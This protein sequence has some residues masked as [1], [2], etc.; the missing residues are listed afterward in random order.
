MDE[1][2][3]GREVGWEARPGE[4]GEWRPAPDGH[5]VGLSAPWAGSV[6]RSSDDTF[7]PAWLLE[8]AGGIDDRAWLASQLHAHL[9]LLG[10]YE[11]VMDLALGAGLRRVDRE[12]G[13]ESLGCSS[14]RDLAPALYGFS[15]SHAKELM[16]LHEKLAPLPR[17]RAAFVSNALSRSKVRE[18]ARVAKPDDEAGWLQVGKQSSVRDLKSAI[19]DWKAGLR[20]VHAPTASQEAEDD[21]APDTH[22]RVRW[23]SSEVDAAIFSGWGR[24]MLCTV[25]GKDAPDWQLAEVLAAETLADLGP[26]SDDDEPRP[27]CAGAR[28][29][30]QPGN[31]P[32]GR[33]ATVADETGA[34]PAGGFL[35]G[36]GAGFKPALPHGAPHVRAGAREKRRKLRARELQ[37]LARKG[38]RPVVVHAAPQLPDPM[39]AR[40]ATEVHA[41]LFE[42]VALRNAVEW[43]RGQLLD[44]MH[45]RSLYRELGVRTF[46]KYLLRALGLSAREGFGAVKL[47]RSLDTLPHVER[48]LREARL[49]PRT[50]A[51]LVHD[52]VDREDEGRGAQ[53]RPC[54]GEACL[55][56]RPIQRGADT[57]QVEVAPRRAGPGR[58]GPYI[59]GAR[60]SAAVRSTCAGRFE[61]VFRSSYMVSGA[62]CE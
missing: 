48:A 52:L 42:I 31:A 25:L 33:E 35:R 51:L 5:E 36:V 49:P 58:P 19:V 38:R 47:Q 45:A 20:D 11:S 60:C 29:G 39:A 32:R 44:L 2:R 37:R 7:V 28:S 30:R 10:S 9:R 16:L 23:L 55:A 46:D 34:M 12:F 24:S 3:E 15:W 61:P 57:R 27:R 50:A 14:G 4:A 56:R 40:T 22:V 43:E 21:H 6:R 13:V 59:G 8:G 26:P 54:R 53:R 17:L 41:S 1:G 18:L 62:T